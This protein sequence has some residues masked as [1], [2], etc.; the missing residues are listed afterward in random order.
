MGHKF[1]YLQ[2]GSLT[3]LFGFGDRLEESYPGPQ[4]NMEWFENKDTLLL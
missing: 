2:G 1:E 4:Q 3:S